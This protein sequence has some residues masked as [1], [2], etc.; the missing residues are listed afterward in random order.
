MTIIFT[1]GGSGG[2]IFPIL[3]IIREL[4]KKNDFSSL[5]IY[6]LGNGDEYSLNLLRNEGVKVKK[7]ASGKIRRYFSLNNIPDLIFKL[8]AGV[9]QSFFW[10]FFLF[11]DIVFSK[12]GS[13]S[14]PVALAA[15]TLGVSLFLHESDSAPGLSSKIESKWATEI[16]TS[17]LDKKIFPQKKIISIGNPIRKEILNGDAKKAK[18]ILA[19]Q[20]DKPLIFIWGGSQGANKI[21]ETIM[22]ILDDLVADFELVHQTGQRNIKRLQIEARA[23]LGKEE[24]VKRYHPVPFLKEEE[25]K[26]ILARADLVITRAGAGS[27]FEIAA[28]GKAAIVIPLSNSA[29]NHQTKNAYEFSNGGGGEVIEERNLRPHFFLEKIRHLF[30]RR[31]ILRQM[32]QNSKKFARPRAAEIIAS[33]MVEYI[34]ALEK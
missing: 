26:H 12:G 17:F 34:K 4:K 8:P 31:D 2:H 6:F 24:L 19:L 14:F 16:F 25:L 22:A 10:V 20:G 27:L 18:E 33:Y 7:I 15:K 23:L 11:P 30:K 3:A 1:G 29:Q 9:I 13:N 32:E 28:V 21:N 5:K